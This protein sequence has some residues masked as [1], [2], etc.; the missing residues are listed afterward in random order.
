M[1][2]DLVGELTCRCDHSENKVYNSNFTMILYLVSRQ[3]QKKTHSSCQ[4]NH[5]FAV[6]QF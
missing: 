4:K 5:N 6:F 3:K 1:A 2:P